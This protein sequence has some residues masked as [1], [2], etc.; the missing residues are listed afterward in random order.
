MALV[1]RADAMALL[2]RYLD[3]KEG[4]HLLR[5]IF[6]RKTEKVKLTWRQGRTAVRSWDEIPAV[7]DRVNALVTEGSENSTFQWTAGRYLT[8]RGLKAVS[9]GCGSGAREI[10]WAQTGCFDKIIG[11]DISETRI[12]DARQKAAGSE[13]EGVAE[14]VSADVLRFAIEPES[15]DVILAEGALHH[16]APLEV[17]FEKIRRSLKLGGLLILNDYVGPDR[18]Q[19]TSGQMRFC[20]VLLS[21]I[22]E[23]MRTYR[24]TYVVKRR[25]GR[26]GTLSMRIHDPSEAVEPSKTLKLIHDGFTVLS[27]GDYGG[28]ILHPLLKDIA[29]HFADGDAEANEV[30]RFLFAAEDYLMQSGMIG[31][32]FTFIV[33]KK[34]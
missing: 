26:P 14:F 29:H 21:F 24:G 10:S 4:V 15:L 30:L 3:E 27:R 34:I 31:S 17:V 2:L 19:W 12:A 33:A 1:T 11:V 6:S 18:F 25:I 9:L 23:S 13:L 16:L 8:Q 28:T 22:P 5:R 7:I 20:D 32:D